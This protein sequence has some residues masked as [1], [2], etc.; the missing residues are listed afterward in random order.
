MR[1]MCK[2]HI[3]KTHI[4]DKSRCFSWVFRTDTCAVWNRE[5][6]IHMLELMF[7][8]DV[9]RLI[10]VLIIM[11]EKNWKY[12]TDSGVKILFICNVM[13]TVL[14][15]VCKYFQF[16]YPVYT[17]GKSKVFL[18]IHWYTKTKCCW[19]CGLIA[20]VTCRKLHIFYTTMK[21]F[22]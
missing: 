16:E 15:W 5:V 1:E 18:C 17:G 20:D 8:V 2:E 14:F 4:L 9:S 19:S 7:A 11:W 12:K 3:L 21:E 6:Y 22:A 10:S 13:P